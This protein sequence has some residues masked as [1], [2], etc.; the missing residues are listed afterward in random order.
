MK[1][2][3]IYIPELG[4]VFFIEEIISI[5]DITTFKNDNE[6]LGYFEIDFKCRK[7]IKIQSFIV[8]SGDCDDYY[9]KKF[10]IKV[11]ESIRNQFLQHCNIINAQ[12]TDK[13]QP[14]LNTDEY[15]L[16]CKLLNKEGINSGRIFYVLNRVVDDTVRTAQI[17]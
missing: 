16:I 14:L 10:D 7:K 17:T 15:H 4:K 8:E 12:E 13:E 2:T 6:V 3:A 9:Y 11:L 5:S 1:P